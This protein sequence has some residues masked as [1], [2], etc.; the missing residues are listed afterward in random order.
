MSK[1]RAQHNN[2][3]I[4]LRLPEEVKNKIQ[5][6]AIREGLSLNSAIVQRLVWSLDED[7]KNG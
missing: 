7:Q 2:A 6:K 4:K 3:Q 5:Q 1:E